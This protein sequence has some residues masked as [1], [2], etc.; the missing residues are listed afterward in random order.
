[1]NKTLLILGSLVIVA[2]VVVWSIQLAEERR[3]QSEIDKEIV[4]E[5]QISDCQTRAYESYNLDWNDT[6]KIVGKGNDCLLPT[7]RAEGIDEDYQRALDRCVM[8]Y[9]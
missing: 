4:K 1:M 5:L 8:L 6:C 7:W 3:I 9:K 2:L